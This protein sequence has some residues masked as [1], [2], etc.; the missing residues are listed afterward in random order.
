MAKDTQ[1]PGEAE[2]DAP[3]CVTCGQPIGVNEPIVVVLEGSVL[4]TSRA[5]GLIE[6]NQAVKPRHRACF[7]AHG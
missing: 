4:E 1:P 6:V 2:A 7:E 5:A 3:T